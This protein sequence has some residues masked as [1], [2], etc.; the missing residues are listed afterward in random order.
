MTKKFFRFLLLLTVIASILLGQTLLVRANSLS[1]LPLQ[2][3][4]T[5]QVVSINATKVPFSVLENEEEIVLTGPFDAA[6]FTFALPDAW[7][8]SPGTQLFLSMT[9]N[10]NR[11]F[12][13]EFGYPIV[14]S[15]GT[16]SVY[17]NDNL[18]GML[19]LN[20]T[21]QV[22]SVLPIPLAAFIS[23]RPDG[24]MEFY[25][26][27]DAEDFCYIDEAFTLI[28]HSTSYFELPHEV[29]KPRVELT[30]LPA[31][32]Y[33]NTFISQSALLV[34]SDQPSAAELQAALTVAAALGS[35]S[36][37]NLALD[38]TTMSALTPQQMTSNHIILVGKASSLNLTGLEF[39]LKP[40]GGQFSNFGGN[41]E[42]GII[43]MINSPW[44]I[45]HVVLHITGNTDAAIVKAAQAFST[46]ILQ[47]NR[48]ANLAIVEEIRLPQGVPAILEKRT[49]AEMGYGNLTFNA[50][51]FRTSSYTFQIPP[52]WTVTGDAYFELLFGN[53]A[54]VDFEQSGI[55]V[56][57]NGRPIGSVRLDA[58]TAKNS[59]NRAKMVLPEFAILPGTN[60]LEI[61][62][63]L[64]PAAFCAPPDIRGLWAT[65]WNQSVLNTPIIQQP[66]DFT[67]TLGLSDYPAPFVYDLELGTT[68]FVFSKGDLD[69]WR[70]AA[71][72]ASY[73]AYRA[74]PQIVTLSAFYSDELPAEVRPNYNFLLI[75]R[76]SQ[77]S[78]V[79]DL[80]QYLP[81]PFDE[82]D[83]ALE[84]SLRVRYN[85]PAN[86]PLGYIEFLTS[87]WNSEN[88]IIA[89]FGNT[90]QGVSSAALTLTD[91]LLRS[92]VSGNFVIVN[93][94]QIIASDTRVFPVS[95]NPTATS[96]QQ[97]VVVP[98][99]D[100]A[101]QMAQKQHVDWIPSAILIITAIIVVILAI[102]LIGP[103]KQRLIRRRNIAKEE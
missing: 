80:K 24:L 30:R 20:E 66:I 88:V 85:I 96:D 87:P 61:Q 48:L 83:V 18:L 15:G 56:L 92:H 1:A 75:G 67:N 68:A 51:G 10:F 81:V 2:V 64:V 59:V 55:N 11:S 46:R 12:Y 5:T 62:I 76:P 22:E 60:Q 90:L 44:D 53:S 72:I 33:Q 102:V 69:A 23:E 39:P 36:R 14:A 9:V 45:S 6:D 17:L 71:R 84:N 54:L 19:N 37:N 97:L 26:E 4:P 100:L 49:L 65:V 86:N 73:L 25:V 42:D 21:G 57:L 52:G 101:S 47:P 38:L 43:Q 93:G 99:M 91:D 13:S 28:I 29:V 16:L 70:G 95:G 50:R 82:N 7:V 3:I 40:S 8:L 27:L 32:L 79:N 98:T 89:L 41:P 35:F 94:N 78:V 74:S 63:N 77:L 34:V 31:P 58:E 103:L